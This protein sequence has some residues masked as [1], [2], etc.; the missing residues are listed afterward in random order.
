MPNK[1]RATSRSRQN[2]ASRTQVAAWRR[3]YSAFVMVMHRPFLP[4]RRRAGIPLGPTPRRRRSSRARQILLCA[5]PEP[6]RKGEKLLLHPGA[7]RLHSPAAGLALF[8]MSTVAARFTKRLDDNTSPPAC[9]KSSKSLARSFLTHVD[10][11]QAVGI[12]G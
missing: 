12:T 2:F 6:A 8:P 11:G 7:R 1:P 5:A 10:Q 4:A 9:S 3:K